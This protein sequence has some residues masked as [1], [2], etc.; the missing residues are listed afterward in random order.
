MELIDYDELD[1]DDLDLLELIVSDS[2]TANKYLLFEGSNDETYAINVSKVVEILVFKDLQM[3]K[4]GSSDTLIRGTAQIRDELSTIIN[5]DEW[6]GNEVLD[7]SEYEYII[8]AGFGGYNL[9]IMIKSVDYIVSV[10][11]IDMKDNSINNP[12]TNFLTQIKLNNQEK[13]C[14]IFDC[15]KLLLDV[16]DDTSKKNDLEK[17]DLDKNIK[18]DRLI[19]FA[20]DSR[21][22]RKMVEGLFEKLEVKYKIFENGKDLYDALLTYKPEDIGLVVTDI[23][24]PIM[25]GIQLIKNINEL[26]GYETINI[27]VHTNMGKFVVESSLVE[28]GVDDIIS[29]IDIKK[30][31]SSILKY[32]NNE[33]R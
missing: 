24:M 22:I 28:L 11:S 4:N 30:L 31:S 27:I 15:D 26:E 3:V 25:D 23:E 9:G 29:K 32:F 5:F 12:K 33:K 16:F 13:L 1:N 7:D 14:T 18:S 8:L 17:M 10:D 6:F 2:S 19:L 20:D 21:F